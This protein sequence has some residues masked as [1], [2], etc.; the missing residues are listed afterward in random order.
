MAINYQAGTN[1]V[2][3]QHPSDVVSRNY[4]GSYAFKIKSEDFVR[5]KRFVNEKSRLSLSLSLSLRR[6]YCSSLDYD[7]RISI[8][9]EFAR[10]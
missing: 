7:Q 9:Q 4:R 5:K 2:L 8:R 6:R 10:A 1:C 3:P